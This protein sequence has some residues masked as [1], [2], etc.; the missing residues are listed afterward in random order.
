MQGKEF[1]SIKSKGTT[2]TIYYKVT[3]EKISSNKSDKTSIFRLRGYLVFLGTY[4]KTDDSE[5]KINNAVIKTGTIEV[6][7]KGEYNLGFTDITIHHNNTTGVMPSTKISTS[8]KTTY[9]FD[10]QQAE[11]TIPS[12][13]APTFVYITK[14]SSPTMVKVFPTMIGTTGGKIT[15][16]WSGAKVGIENS[17][18]SYAIWINNDNK[19]WNKIK[20]VDSKSTSTTH[21]IGRSDSGSSYAI[22]VEANSNTSGYSSG[23]SNAQATLNINNL[24]NKPIFNTSITISNSGDN[25]NIPVTPGASNDSGQISKVYYSEFNNIENKILA[26]KNIISINVTWANNEVQ[27]QY[28]VWTYDGYDYSSTAETLTITRNSIPM[29][30]SITNNYNESKPYILNTATATGNE[31]NLTYKWYYRINSST[32]DKEIQ[33]YTEN[34][35]SNINLRNLDGVNSGNTIKIGARAIDSYGDKSNIV[36]GDSTVIPEGNLS[37]S[38]I[39]DVYSKLPSGEINNSWYNNEVYFNFDATK[40][41]SSFGEIKYNI[42]YRL[43]QS[44]SGDNEIYGE[45]YKVDYSTITNS[46]LASNIARGIKVKFELIFSDDIG[47][48]IV[49]DTITRI[50]LPNY[51]GNLKISRESIRPYSDSS[52]DIVVFNFLKTQSNYISP[53]DFSYYIVYT[54]IYNG[55][56]V[57][58]TGAFTPFLSDGNTYR[59]SR[60]IDFIKKSF[61]NTYRSKGL[62]LNKNYNTNFLIYVKDIFGNESSRSS[63]PLLVNFQESPKWDAAKNFSLYKMIDGSYNEILDTEL[64]NSTKRMINANMPGFCV[65]VPKISD[66]N[67]DIIGYELS[68]TTKD[69]NDRDQNNN[70][71][72][73]NF[74]TDIYQIVQTG[75][76]VSNNGI[77]SGY[78]SYIPKNID[79][80]KFAKF[81]LRIFDSTGLYSTFLDSSTYVILCRNNGIKLRVQDVIVSNDNQCTVYYNIIDTG[82]NLD[83]NFDNLYIFKNSKNTNK[84]INF[85]LSPSD[86]IDMVWGT[87]IQI[88]D[89]VISE[90]VSKGK[91]SITFSMNNPNNPPNSSIKNGDKLTFEITVPTDSNSNYQGAYENYTYYINAPTISKRA[92]RIGINTNNFTSL[93]DTNTNGEVLIIRS[94]NQYRIIKLIDDSDSQNIKTI[95]INLSNGEIDGAIING[96]EW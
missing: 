29:I 93:V 14:N 17:I 64:Y 28:K 18:S 88:S 90:Y 36:Y 87:S 65:Y 69:V 5:I 4:Y 94:F 60:S 15:I 61:E 3:Y 48:L 49:E 83:E 7:K 22:K 50:T 74:D 68:M 46:F 16:S 2:S 19:G 66:K 44:G 27:K 12:E 72:N 70:L 47:E 31:T 67:N 23:M 77:Y 63:A 33:G 79:K 78:I 21:D 39:F 84:S 82:T 6:L 41:V 91:Y 76:I 45:R 71:P 10:S 1:I 38:G 32:E 56:E 30:K 55:S 25:I 52:E 96:G 54:N 34:I 81:R 58:F 8:I 42:Y 11:G 89:N 92:H 13:A 95:T 62:P 43:F 85:I 51:N 9:G 86:R 24:P 53:I 40:A 20:T 73:F 75:T 26:V 80:P 57:E 35:I 37:Y 59:T